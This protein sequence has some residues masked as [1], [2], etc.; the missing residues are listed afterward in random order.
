MNGNRYI[1]LTV[2]DNGPGIAANILDK[3]FTTNSGVNSGLT[4]D[5]NTSTNP[6]TNLSTKGGS[7]TGSGLA[8][9]QN[10]GAELGGQISCQTTPASSASA[11]G[12][13]NIFEN[14]GTE[15]TVLLPVVSASKNPP[16]NTLN[17]NKKCRDVN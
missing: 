7:H 11:S 1:Q 6:G 14:S 5:A 12:L 4:S 2:K 9:V 17:K 10:R 13:N 16:H 8:I 3:L 15:I